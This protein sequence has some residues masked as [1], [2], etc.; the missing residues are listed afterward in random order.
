MN[1]KTLVSFSAGGAL[2][3][4]TPRALAATVLFDFEAQADLRVMRDEGGAG[5]GPGK[6]VERAEQFATSGR[7]ALKFST[8]KWQPGQPRWPAFECQPPVSNW[9]G[10]DRLAFDVT[11]VS[12]QPQTLSLF[13]S[14]SKTPTRQGLAY[15]ARLAPSS[16]TPV[17]IPLAQL[18][19]KK[20]NPADIHVVHFFTSEPPGLMTLFLDRFVL[21]KPGEAAPAVSASFLKE[22][23]AL[24]S[25]RVAAARAAVEEA[26]ARIG[27]Q[28]AGDP[29]VADWARRALGDI[30]AHVAAFSDAVAQAGPGV[31]EAGRTA[32]A[33]TGELERLDSAARFR[34]DFEAIRSLAQTGLAARTDMAVGFATSMEKIL[35]RVAPFSLTVTNRVALELAQN[36]KESF[37]VLMLPCERDLRR[38]RVRIG[39]LRADGGALFAST[40][41]K[42]APVGYVQTKAEPPYGAARVGWW[43]DP[44]LDFLDTADI[45][46][47]DLQSFWVRVRAPKQQ[48][49][50]RYQGKLEIVVDGAPVFSFDLAVRVFS[51]AL[52]DRS[53][54]PLAITFAPE[55][56][57]VPETREQQTAWRRSPDY[58]INAWREQK[59]RWADFLSDYYIT[60]DSLYHSSIPDFELLTHLRDQGRLD[61]FNLGY[62]GFAPTNAAE[63]E[64]WKAGNL[65]RFREG[66]TKAKKLG[67]LHH[68]YIYGC[69]EANAEDFPQVQNAASILKTEFPGVLIMT[70]TRDPSYGLH[71]VMT[72]MDAF[73]PLTPSFDPDQ[74]IQARAAGKQVWW[75]ICC[76]PPHPYANMFIEYPAIE[77]RLLMGAMTAKYRPDG[78]LYYQI[79]IWNS[80]K[81]IMAGPFTDWDPRSWTTYHGDGSWTCVGPRGIP[82]PTIRLEN[83]RDGLEDYAYVRL[84]ESARA[85]VE[86]SPA[87]RDQKAAW[88]KQARELLAVPSEVLKSKTE[89]THDP[90]T[91][92]KWRTRMAEAIMAADTE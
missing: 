8:P 69:D 64:A 75:Y 77:G 1:F 34:T 45:A 12:E 50:G 24:Q 41:I 58:A 10:F 7:F 6:T 91:V 35:P 38:V 82:L 40:N 87:L 33:I 62:Y 88:L 78:F 26:R 52:P 68:A 49:P 13:I 83:F 29:E 73:C 28:T 57:P 5:L 11:S 20:V 37:Q 53:P 74:A 30:D 71:S 54:L 14:D 23:A 85:R 70:T 59:P 32:A 27:R 39:D 84:L 90:S 43:P 60:Y 81:P 46:K 56:S 47:N 22:C 61:M 4:G 80:Q 63:T 79:S 17:V 16:Y 15:T 18:E 48:P 2:L 76:A 55:D 65:P 44:I 25:G 86:A 51:F 89:F 19:E 9:S 67:L 42:A 21:L 3:M 66:Y 36:E 92:Y 72:S 31:L